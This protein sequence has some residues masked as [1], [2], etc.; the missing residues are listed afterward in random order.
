MMEP[1]ASP[2]EEIETLAY[3]CSFHSTFLFFPEVIIINFLKD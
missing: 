1:M 3:T 2:F